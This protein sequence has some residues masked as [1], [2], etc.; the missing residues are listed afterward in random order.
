MSP[1]APAIDPD[2]LLGLVSS[3]TGLSRLLCFRVIECWQRLG[4]IRLDREGV[5]LAVGRD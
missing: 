2:R 3:E 4:L 1:F 5:R